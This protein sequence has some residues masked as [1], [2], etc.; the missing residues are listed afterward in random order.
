MPKQT[1]S[2]PKAPAA[3]GPYSQGVIANGFVFTSG[4]IPLR[5]DGTMVEGDIQAMARQCLDNI[6]AILESAGTT[7]NDLVKVTVFAKD[8]NNFQ[9]INDVYKTYF[10]QSPPARSFVEVSNLPRNAQVEMEGIAV[11]PK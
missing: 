6:K 2:T 8:M 7:M 4:Q 3:V 1:V 9:A 5:P 10:N 11:L